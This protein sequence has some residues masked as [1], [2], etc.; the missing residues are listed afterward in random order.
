MK[1]RC[2][3]VAWFGKDPSFGVSVIDTFLILRPVSCERAAWVK[4]ELRLFVSLKELL[5]E[6]ELVLFPCS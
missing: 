6:L 2:K 3:G 4:G 1:Y 5:G